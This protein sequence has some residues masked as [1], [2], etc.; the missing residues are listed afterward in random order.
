MSKS[1]SAYTAKTD[2]INQYQTDVRSLLPMIADRLTSRIEA[3]G[4]VN[5][6]AGMG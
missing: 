5:A 6:R 4:P 3:A 2:R 1:Q